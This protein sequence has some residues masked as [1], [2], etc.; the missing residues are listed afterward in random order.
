[1]LCACVELAPAVGHCD[2]EDDKEVSRDGRGRLIGLLPLLLT[3][4]AC[5]SRTCSRWTRF[6]QALRCWFE[7]ARR[8]RDTRVW[9]WRRRV[10]NET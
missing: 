9:A 5:L 8:A 3:C 6:A 10:P 7:F 4:R 2:D 1:L